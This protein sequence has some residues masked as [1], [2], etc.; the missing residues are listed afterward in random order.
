MEEHLYKERYWITFFDEDDETFLMGFDNLEDICRYKNLPVNK[1]NIDT[2]MINL[3]RALKR[4]TH[5]TEMLIP[6]HP[7]HVYLI[8]ML[9]EEI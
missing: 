2:I 4:E 5:L 6:G 1:R 7:M 9:D 3:Y 8:D